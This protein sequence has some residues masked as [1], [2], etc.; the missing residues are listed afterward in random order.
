MPI[1]T[2]I[3]VSIMVSPISATLAIDAKNQIVMALTVTSPLASPNMETTPITP[4]MKLNA[5]I[6][7][8]GHS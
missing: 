4:G 8:G 2:V 5:D 7:R 1:I 3:M 6:I